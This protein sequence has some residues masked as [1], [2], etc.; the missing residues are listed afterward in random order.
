MISSGQCGGGHDNENRCAFVTRRNRSE[1]TCAVFGFDNDS[2]YV[3]GKWVPADEKQKADILNEIEINCFR[4][5]MTCVQ[6]SAEYYMSYPHVSLG[7]F[8]V[9]RWDKDGI[10]STDS[11]KECMTL[12]MQV[13][14]AE[15]S[16]LL[17]HSMKQLDTKEKGGVQILWSG[18]NRARNSRRQRVRKVEQGTHVSSKMNERCRPRYRS[19]LFALIKSCLRR[20][21]DKSYGHNN[22]DQPF[23]DKIVE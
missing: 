23:D 9:I 18:E 1:R 8:D 14:F 20:D 13:S 15:K 10:I 5:T 21:G 16:V 7:Y 2:F 4:K 11:T 6:G 3:V 12:T 19:K 22:K 17:V